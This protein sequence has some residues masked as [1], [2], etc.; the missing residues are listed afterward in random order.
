MLLIINRENSLILG[1]STAFI[2]LFMIMPQPFLLAWH[3]MA[4]SICL[5]S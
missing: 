1:L 3:E 5:Y 4:Y 2:V